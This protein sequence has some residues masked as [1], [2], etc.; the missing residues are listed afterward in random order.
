MKMAL[1]VLCLLALVGGF[2]WA[3][4]ALAPDAADAQALPPSG[5]S[6]GGSGSNTGDV[7]LGSFGSSPS[8]T[9][10]SLSSQILTLQPADA[11]HPGLVSAAAQT[12]GGIKAADGLQTVG[13]TSGMTGTNNTF[14]GSLDSTHG[15]LWILP[16]ATAPTTTNA[17]IQRATGEYT[18][19]YGESGTGVSFYTGTTLRAYIDSSAVHVATVESTIASG[20][21]GFKLLT[22][23]S[24]LD[25]GTGSLDYFKSDGT[26]IV[27]PGEIQT[28]G[29]ANASLPTCNGT[30]EGAV[31]YD[32]TNHKHVG[33]NGTAWTNLY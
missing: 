20:S 15:A 30:T 17:A 16:T 14:L 9:G 26:R 10:A 5:S 23:G 27:T 11:T 31:D 32:T 21:Y 29:V 1:R 24:R 22:D 33:C 19:L 3:G 13:A 6:S 2:F 4:H 28:L 18:R 8:A 12:F 7:T 25:I